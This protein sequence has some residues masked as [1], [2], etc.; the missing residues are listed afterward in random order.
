MLRTYLL[1]GSISVLALMASAPQADAQEDRWHIR[2]NGVLVEPDAQFSLDDNNIGADGSVGLGLAVERRFSRRLGLELGALFAE[3]DVNLDAA[4]GEGQISASNRIDF[5][6]I[7][8]GLNIHLTPDKPFDLYLGPVLAH[9]DYSDVRLPG[10]IGGQAVA[11]EVSSS[12]NFTVGAQIGADIA[13]GASP[14]SLNLIARYLDSSLD[15]VAG[16]G[17]VVN[18]LEFDPLIAGV[19]F[20][21][22]F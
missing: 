4:V 1:F 8:L 7:H 20:G 6:S 15:A 21:F 22:K 11:V 14:W 19:G 18:Q 10:Q 17:G 3:P 13:F 9:V 2:F 5:T 16:E 12:D